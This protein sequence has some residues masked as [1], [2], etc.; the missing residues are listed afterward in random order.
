MEEKIYISGHKNP[1]TDSIMSAI[2]AE[3][4]YTQLGKNVEAIMQG[5]P[6][7]ETKFALEKL[8]LKIPR[9]TTSLNPGSK[10][11]LVD[12]NYKEESLDNIDELQIIEVIDHHAVKLVVGYPLYYRAEPVGCTCSILYKKF[13]ENNVEIPEKIALAMLTAI[14]SDTLLLK[15]PTC[16]NEDIE[17]VNKLEKIAKVD[18]NVYGLELL[19]AGTDLSA[20][21]FDER[22]SLDAKK[23]NLG[24]SDV[25]IA[26]ITTADIKEAM[27]DLDNYKKVINEK[28]EKDNLD[29]FMLLITDIINSDSQVI[30]LGNKKEKVASAYNVKLENDTA[31][32]KGIVSRK[33]QVIPVLTEEF[34]K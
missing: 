23:A 14:I 1:D 25:I 8:G 32:L 27:E 10:V 13:V 31:F 30:A 9:K 20:Y 2:V 6:S 21:T 12:H 24:G 16:T 18:K 5:E 33:K 26:Q 17:I 11:I 22:I 19:K 7:A 3:Y 29:L 28:I 15:S 34:N 4:L